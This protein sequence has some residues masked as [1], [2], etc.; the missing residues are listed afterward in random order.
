MSTP[1]EERDVVLDQAPNTAPTEDEKTRP[2]MS[3]QHTASVAPS[4]MDEIGK[5]GKVPTVAQP[6]ERKPRPEDRSG[7][8]IILT[9]EIRDLM[10]A[11]ANAIVKDKTNSYT[12]VK[13]EH[14]TVIVR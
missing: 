14:D 8:V 1:E 6:K 3:I 5:T 10:L 13:V 9:Q 7:P 12:K 4:T 2:S 11:E